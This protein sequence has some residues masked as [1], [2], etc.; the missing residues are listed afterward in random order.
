MP[1]D[2][3]ERLRSKHSHRVQVEKQKL[4]MFSMS[5]PLSDRFS[6]VCCQIKA[7]GIMCMGK[8]IFYTIKRLKSS[9]IFYI[10]HN[11]NESHRRSKTSDEVIVVKIQLIPLFHLDLGYCPS[12][13][14]WHRSG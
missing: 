7:S 6:S 13:T 5:Q 8:W 4:T 10:F 14:L 12:V 2:L 1:G 9:F 3:S 11:V